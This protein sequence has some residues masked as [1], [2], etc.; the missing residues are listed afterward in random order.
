MKSKFEQLRALLTQEEWE[1]FLANQ[2]LAEDTFESSLDQ[3][4]LGS[5]NWE[6]S[7]QGHDYWEA[8]R[9][10]VRNNDLVSETFKTAPESTPQAE[11]QPQDKQEI[12][13][14]TVTRT[15][16]GWAGHFI[17]SNCC[18]FRRNTLLSYPGVRIVVST[19]GLYRDRRTDE[20]NTIGCE[21]HYETMAF[22]AEFIDPY[23]EID[24][25]RQINF[26]SNWS[27]Y[28]PDGVPREA[29]MAANDMHETVV[30]EIINSLESGETYEH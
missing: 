11:I 28:Y 5:F 6:E 10:R 15:E 22:H 30:N 18:L 12:K 3:I 16:R 19:V 2:Y 27:L 20:I 25:D 24:T 29:D 17:A 26:D 9:E 21:R 14:S 1:N 23:W 7:P 4:I 13:M 8:I